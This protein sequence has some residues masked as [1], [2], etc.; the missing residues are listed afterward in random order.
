MKKYPLI[1]FSIA[2]ACL[3]VFASFTNVVGVVTIKSSN[4][5]IVN[6]EV[7]PKELL[8]QTII[9]I[10]NNKEFQKVILI[11]ETKGNGFFNY[12]LKFLTFTSKILTKK[13]LN[14]A[15]HIGLI[16]SKTISKSKIHSMVQKCQL[17]YY[18]LQKKMISLIEKND[19]LNNEI[20]QL[21]CLKCNCTDNKTGWNFPILCTILWPL[22]FFTLAIWVVY[23]IFYSILLIVKS[24]GLVLNCT[25]SG[26]PP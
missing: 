7:N 25:W 2:V 22:Y 6:E 12:D 1:G 4:Q 17:N 15:Y 11:H 24:I 14:T 3:I 5:K 18:N 16:L 20:K 8:F 13:Y 21:S 19:T 23:D 10:A 26:G 9:D